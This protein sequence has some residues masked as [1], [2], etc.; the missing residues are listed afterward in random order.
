VTGDTGFAGN[1]PYKIVAMRPLISG[2]TEKLHTGKAINM[3][4][5]TALRSG[6]SGMGE[7]KRSSRGKCSLASLVSLYRPRISSIGTPVF[8]LLI[9]LMIYAGWQNSPERPLTAESGLG[10]ALG[11]VGGVLMLLLLLYPLRKHSRSFR[12]L[13]PVKYW[14][15]V[16][17]LF[18]ILG[19]LCIIFHCG[20][21]LGS[22][23]SNIALFSMLIVACSGLF[24][25]YF[26]IR[27]HHGLYGHKAT[28]E[29]L[30]QHSEYLKQSLLK[31]E[32]SSG[33]IDSI[34]R[35]REKTTQVH[36][37]LLGSF[38][39]LLAVGLRTWLVFFYIQLAAL[40][41]Q[42][43]RQK[44][45][46]T[47]V[48]LIGAYLASI[49]KVAEFHFYQKLFAAWHVLHFPL[50]LLMVGAGIVHVIAVHMY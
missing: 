35:Y 42:V 36:Q 32:I 8:Y 41:P 11:I 20:F 23:N 24:G 9:L 45:R 48:R 21:Q 31:L 47:A 16:H 5:D 28:L 26:Y 6:A 12:R 49:R 33:I 4:I 18:G 27:I 25:R 2:I 15:R 46:K 13:G 3:A 34:D 30:Q 43:V 38:I 44:Y 29:E 14:F 37:G 7:A 19:P 17:M 50:F 39:A 22:L 40:K 10:Y 1:P